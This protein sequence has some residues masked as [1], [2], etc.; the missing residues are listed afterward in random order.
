MDRRLCSWMNRQ[1]FDGVMSFISIPSLFATMIVEDSFRSCDVWKDRHEAVLHSLSR[2]DVARNHLRLWPTYVRVSLP[3]SVFPNVTVLFIRW[4]MMGHWYTAKQWSW[5]SPTAGSSQLRWQAAG[6][7][8]G[9]QF[10]EQV[11]LASFC[12]LAFTLDYTRPCIHTHTHIRRGSFWGD[13]YYVSKPDGFQSLFTVHTWLFL[14][15]SVQYPPPS[16]F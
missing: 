8:P 14:N 6:R 13:A 16:L 5:A 3:S 12:G 7:C 2:T 9:W 1:Q 11:S 15:V 4:L 10:G